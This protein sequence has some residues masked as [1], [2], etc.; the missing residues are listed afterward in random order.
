MELLEFRHYYLLL[1]IHLV[2]YLKYIFNHNESSLYHCL[3]LIIIKYFSNIEKLFENKVVC[4]Q[5]HS[6]YLD[7][8]LSN[9]FQNIFNS[10]K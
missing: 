10:Y 9:T 5:P 3:A 4:Q 6:N 7:F 1:C 8:K 2:S